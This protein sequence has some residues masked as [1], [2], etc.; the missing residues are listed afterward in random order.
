MLTMVYSVGLCQYEEKGYSSYLLISCLC[1]DIITGIAMLKH[2]VFV[3]PFTPTYLLAPQ[4][5]PQPLFL[6]C[7]LP[8]NIIA[9]AEK[10]EAL[11]A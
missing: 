4:I 6:F 1:F 2:S 3:M 11:I 9:E 5:C 10:K 8:N 7:K